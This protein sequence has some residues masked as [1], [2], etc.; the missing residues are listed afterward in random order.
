M[1]YLRARRREGFISVIAWF[2]VARHRAGRGHLDH[3][4][5]RHERIP[6]GTSFA[7]PRH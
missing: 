4:D 2:S 6:R 3:R 5:V 7:Y 1:R